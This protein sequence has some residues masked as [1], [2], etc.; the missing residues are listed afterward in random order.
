MTLRVR[1]LLALLALAFLP[2]LTF[3][4]FTLEQL[5]RATD[6]WYVPGVDHA[7]EA[8]LEVSRA[9]L[10]RIEATALERADDWAAGLGPLPL[11]ASRRAGLRDGLR[12]GGLDFAQVYMRREGRW[13]LTD[14]V[15]PSG[16]LA[17]DGLDFATEI[18][19]TLNT[20]RLLHSSQG[21]LAA[22]AR[23]DT[24]SA[25]VVGVRLT[26]D[27]FGRLEE[28]GQARGL[29][30]RLGLLV[31]LQRSY[32]WMMVAALGVALLVSAGFL[33]RMISSD[34][35]RP[36]R[37]LS[38]GFE[39][40]AGGD[41]SARVP[42][43]GATEM[44]LLATSFN[45][46]TSNL[47][48]ARTQLAAAER[49]AAWREVARR[50][51]HEIK[52]PLTPMRLSLHRLQRR[53][54]LVPPEQRPAVR[55]SLNALLEEVEHLTRLAEQFS[56]YARLPEP[57]H[58]RFDLSALARS[59]AALHEPAHASIQLHCDRAY[60]VTGDRLL[61]S[62]AVHNLVLNACEASPSG[63]IV[64]VGTGGADAE[65]WLEVLDRGPGLPLDLGDKVFEPYVSTKNRGSGLGLSLVR[66]IATQH[67]GRVTI[68]N[69]EGGGAKA[70]LTLPASGDNH[71]RA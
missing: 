48:E 23:S 19:S 45:H 28:V 41:L 7:L 5:S 64:E 10:T 61:L 24:N 66:D 62:R 20:T 59:A 12:E 56:Q 22:L 38:M 29:Y 26:P 68:E 55:D 58:E 6:R 2:T 71:G 47:S 32:V 37:T 43:E 13:K 25:L 67:G 3:T 9:A 30:Q 49:E 36:L 21:A 69:R 44:R 39:R 17:I 52:N 8:G 60:E 16:V 65:V 57:Q 34:M 53:V 27:F 15:V 18:D 70:R 50:L 4:L 46:M 35:T 40:V 14:M 33:A 54:D 31:Q 1:L 63:A 51:A 42:E 11:D